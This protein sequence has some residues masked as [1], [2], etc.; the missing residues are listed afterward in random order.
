M[1]NVKV[2]NAW[3]KVKLAQV[4]VS[5]SWK[6]VGRIQVKV[7]GSWKNIWT[8]SWKTGTW[9]DC[10]KNCGTGT[11]TRTVTCVRK[12]NGST[13]TNVSDTFCTKLV[14]TKPAT[15]QNCNTQSCGTCKYQVNTDYSSGNAGIFYS[16]NCQKNFDPAIPLQTTLYWGDTQATIVKW[17][18]TSISKVTYTVNGYVYTRGDLVSSGSDTISGVVYEWWNYKICRR[19]A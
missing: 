3:K 17:D 11:Q 8:Y 2:S 4:K 18:K 6:S 9:G 13:N 5:G 7:S 14:G 19:A 10:S 15:S 1:L 12:E 16:W